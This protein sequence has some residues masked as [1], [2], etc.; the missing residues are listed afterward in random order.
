MTVQSGQGFQRNAWYA[1]AEA[2]EVDRQPLRRLALG[3]PLVL[4]RTEAGDAVIL[5]DRCCHRL[6]PLS[7]GQLIG[8]AIEC[9]YHGLRFDPEGRCTHVPGQMKIPARAKVR[10]YPARERYGLIWVWMGNV[11][12]AM[13]TELP[14]WQWAE[15]P[16]W[17]SIQ[18][19]FHIRCSYLL[20]IDNLMD[21]SHIGYVHKTTIGTANDGELAE[22]ETIDADSRVTVRRWLENQPPAPSYAKKLGSNRT[23]D[24]WQLIEFQPPCYIRT[25]KGMGSQVHGTDGYLFDT[26]DTAPPEG[27][28][29]ISRGNTCITPETDSTCHYFTVHCHHRQTDR[30][31]L[32]YI[33]GQTV[34]TLQQ[35][36]E[37]LEATQENMELDPGA[38]MTFIH[39]DTGVEKA[40]Q[41]AR[42]A[43]KA[44]TQAA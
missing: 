4:F 5:E 17:T 1:I 38:R 41:L 35:D 18:G 12:Q 13:Q 29:A 22:I 19:R 2:G 42:L 3:E 21:L 26:V 6:A 23:I 30:K 39:V 28:L 43:I 9:P 32:D 27:A 34:E 15:D 25:F 24:R 31:A 14:N 33:W 40:R 16:E 8:D 44:E 36:V 11:D 7:P 20:A 37:I 10:T